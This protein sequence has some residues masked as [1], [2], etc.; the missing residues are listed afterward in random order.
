MAFKMKGYSAFTNVDDKKRKQELKKL[1]S[2]WVAGDKAKR[3]SIAN[4]V[5]GDFMKYFRKEAKNV[6]YRGYNNKNK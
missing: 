6:N 5:G 1:A 4:V 2:E 3:D